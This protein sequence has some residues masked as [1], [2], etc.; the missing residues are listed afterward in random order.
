MTWCLSWVAA[1]SQRPFRIQ[2]L[3]PDF[4]LLVNGP[5]ILLTGSLDGHVLHFFSSVLDC[6]AM[7]NAEAVLTITVQLP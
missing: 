4:D 2:R 7:F 5:W 1:D 3:A 6:P